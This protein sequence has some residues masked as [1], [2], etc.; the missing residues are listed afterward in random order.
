MLPTITTPTYELTIPSSGKKINVRPFLVREEKLLLMALESKDPRDA[1]DTTKQV[2]KACILDEGINVDK[3]PFFDIDYLFIALRAKSVSETVNV[4]F[5]CEI[6]DCGAQFPATIDIANV[7]VDGIGAVSNEVSLPGLIKVKLKY[8]NYTQVKSVL[9]DDHVLNKKTKLIIASIDTI[10]DKEK[11]HTEK[12]FTPQDLMTFVEALPRS[13][14][15][16]FE[17]WVDSFPTFH[18]ESNAKC[19]KCGYDHKIDYRDFDSF[20]D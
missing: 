20:F 17:R 8:P 2:I 5:T 12:D 19:T 16:K 11:V 14:Y 9:D 13:E 4:T 7:K 3:L 1:I 6:N 10:I 18:V 15:V